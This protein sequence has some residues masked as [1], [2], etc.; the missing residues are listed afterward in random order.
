MAVNVHDFAFNISVVGKQPSIKVVTD[1]HADSLRPRGTR[2]VFGP[3]LHLCRK[4]SRINLVVITDLSWALKYDGRSAWHGFGST[5]PLAILRKTSVLVILGQVPGRPLLANRLFRF[6][7]PGIAR[8][9]PGP[10]LGA[11]GPTSASQLLDFAVD[12]ILSLRFALPSR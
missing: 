8:A 10:I 6:L 5:A 9:L 7:T 1:D 4:A 12:L 2:I 3:L 11:G